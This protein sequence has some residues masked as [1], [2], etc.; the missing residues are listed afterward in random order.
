MEM[1]SSSTLDML[2]NLPENILEIIFSHL[3]IRDVVRT[4]ILS[5]NWR[6]K[7]VSIPHLIFNDKCI[8]DSDSSFGHD[9]L[10]KIVNHVLLLHKGPILTFKISSSHLQTCSEI[11]SWILHLSLNSLTEFKLQI[12]KSRRH[13]VL[14]CLFTFRKLI[15]LTLVGCIIVPPV[16]FKG[17]ECLKNLI[18]Q[19]VTLSNATLKCLVS[20]CPQLESLTLIDM[21]GPTHIEI[22]NP[23]LKYLWISGK[24]IGI[25]FKDLRL[26]VYANI[27]LTTASHPD[28]RRTC[29]FTNILGS[30]LSIQN[31]VIEGWFLQ[32]IA[33][34]DVAR[35]LPSTYNH[36]KSIYLPLN[37]EDMKEILIVICLLNS[38]P[39][40]QE[41]EILFWRNRESA[42]VPVMN[43][44]EAK[45]QLDCTFNKLRVVNMSKLFGMEI[46]LVLT[47]FIL[48]NSP[49]LE[50][51]FISTAKKGIELTLLK[52]LLQF[53]RTS[54]RAKIVHLD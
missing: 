36:L 19:K 21:D 29:N 52:E 5:T 44:Q 23:K 35:K 7:W 47:K 25:S 31:L 11:D 6:Y 32:S 20:A 24:F 48:A 45:D 22:S 28:Q 13:N 43:L 8:P 46:E 42:I 10:L 33:V 50:K 16:K 9:K 15:H 34:G 14:P 18:F 17:F 1:A 27:D 38:S 39:N 49:V 53:K 4:S 41:L 54:Q 51:M 26:L 12:S 30:L 40:L 37:T 3:S 2:S